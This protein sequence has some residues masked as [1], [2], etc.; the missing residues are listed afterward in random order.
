MQALVL[1]VLPFFPFDLIKRVIS[2]TLGL[3]V[4]QTLMMAGFVREER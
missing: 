3:K 1:T 2:V 4:R